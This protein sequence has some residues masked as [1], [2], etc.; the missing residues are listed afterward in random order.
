MDHMIV[1]PYLE[2]EIMFH[3][4]G[5]LLGWSTICFLATN[6][7]TQIYLFTYASN[8]IGI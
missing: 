3:S 2:M 4:I 1:Y 6:V 5:Y 7:D 8:S